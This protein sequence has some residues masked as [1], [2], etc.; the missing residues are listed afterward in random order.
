[1]TD[2]HAP[3][4]AHGVPAPQNSTPQHPSPPHPGAH[5]AHPGPPRRTRAGA[6]IL[7]WVFVGAAV[8]AAVIAG[9]LVAVNGANRGP[10][11]GEVAE[12]Y[13]QHIADG[14]ATAAAALVAPRPQEIEKLDDPS[15]L[16]DEVLGAATER[17]RDV[18]VDAPADAD[19]A[20]SVTSVDVS[21]ALAGERHDTTLSLARDEESGQWQV[22]TALTDRFIVTEGDPAFLLGGVETPTVDSGEVLPLALYPAVYPVAAID[23]TFYE[24]DIDELVIT[25]APDGARKVA[26]VPNAN[27]SEEVQRQVD[28]HLD[29]CATQTTWR[30][31]GCPLSAPLDARTVEVEWT[32]DTY[33]TVELL[34]DG[35]MFVA[36]GGAVRAVYAPSD[37]AEPVTFEGELSTS[38]TVEVSGSAL[39]VTFE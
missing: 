20:A 35:E 28:A 38:G 34:L 32:V 17:I 33:P 39:V 2:P 9:V 27:F 14:D 12:Q 26:V 30:V 24:T 21:F 18:V 31:D 3:Q 5:T 8:L 23:D 4:P 1:M 22:R 15:M 25:G 37:A 7:L 13:L 10:S 16:T 11:A 29:E 36:R 19:D 6:W